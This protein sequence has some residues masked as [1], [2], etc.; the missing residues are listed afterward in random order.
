MTK[1][2]WIIMKSRERAKIKLLEY[3]GN[4]DNGCC[5]REH[6]AIHVCGFKRRQCLYKLVQ[7]DDALFKQAISGDVKACELFYRRFEGWNPTTKIEMGL[8]KETLD[9][10]MNCLPERFRE[11]VRKRM[12][13][14]IEIERISG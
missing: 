14:L 9:L 7:I 8:T 2:I 6:I 3:L 10:I 13:A 12:Q 11:A 5:T 1:R 4:P